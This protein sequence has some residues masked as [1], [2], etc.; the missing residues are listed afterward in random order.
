[1]P[2]TMR[3]ILSITEIKLKSMIHSRTS[4]IR[5][6]SVPS[7]GVNS[8]ICIL[9]KQILQRFKFI[10]LIENSSFFCYDFS[11]TLRHATGRSRHAWIQWRIVITAVLYR[12]A[13]GWR[14]RNDH[15]G[16]LWREYTLDA[17]RWI[18]RKY[19]DNLLSCKSSA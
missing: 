17:H 15:A 18:N 13:N 2:T 16:V 12:R 4:S 8:T 5:S 19:E 6:R 11:Q 14:R 7:L 3:S 10:F 9:T 1:M